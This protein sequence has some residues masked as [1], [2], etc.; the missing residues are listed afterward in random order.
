M[1]LLPSEEMAQQCLLAAHS[2]L[3]NV[4]SITP[5]EMNEVHVLE[6]YKNKKAYIE[7]LFPSIEDI[8]IAKKFPDLTFG[9]T[10]EEE[11]YKR[12]VLHNG[13]FLHYANDFIHHSVV[14]EDIV[15]QPDIITPILKGPPRLLV[16]LP[17]KTGICLSKILIL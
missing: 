1:R 9:N 15:S 17:I 8:K 4:L 3:E 7:S 14:A 16:F 2:E 5:K 12:W 6:Y 11:N 10:K 13:L